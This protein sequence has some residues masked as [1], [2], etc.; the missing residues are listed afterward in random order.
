MVERVAVLS[1]HSSPLLEPGAGDSGGMTVYVRNVAEALREVGVSTDIYTRADDGHTRATELFPGVRVIKVPAGPTGPVLKEEVPGYIDDF[2]DGVRLFA[3][4]QRL[5]YHVIHSHYWPSGLAG[6]RLAAGWDVP[7]VH[8]HHTLGLVKNHRL[9]PGDRPEPQMRV[10]G[11]REVIEAADVLVASTDDDWQQL[12]CLYAAPH[13]RIKTIH[14]GV[15][16]E[17]FSPGPP[18]DAR[19]ITG[20]GDGPVLLYV[21]RIQ[22]LKGLELALRSVEQLV[23][24]LDRPLTLVLVGGPSGPT[25]SVELA[26][27]KTLARDLGIEDHVRFVGP[28]AHAAL[29]DFYRAADALVMCSHS[30][31]FGLA[32]LEAQACG[33]PVVATSTGGLAHIVGEGASGFLVATRDPAVFAARLKT[34]LSDSAL[35]AAFGLEAARRAHAFSWATTA[36]ALLELYECL[37]RREPELCTC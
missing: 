31:S 37:S 1:L 11:E 2:V 35:R 3:S 6:G 30:E 5:R 27:L 20:L 33:L 7:L 12:A 17:V 13:D 34:L 8:S 21:G 19:R 22:P 26:G 24:A 23:P 29:P 4:A 18:D 36:D 25:G 28:K 15:D 14:P 32:A 16:H 10:D 9:A